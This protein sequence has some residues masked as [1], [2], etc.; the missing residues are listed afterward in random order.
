MRILLFIMSIV[1]TQTI[2][3]QELYLLVGTYTSGNSEGIYVCRFNTSTGEIKLV[4]TAKSSNPSYLAIAGKSIYAVNENGGKNGGEV[5]A[6]HFDRKSG[7]LDFLNKQ[8]TGGDHPCY[9]AVDRSK[10]TLLAGNYS[11]GNFSVFPINTDGSLEAYSRLVQNEGNGPDHSRQEK[12]HVHATVFGP[13]QESVW[14]TD[15]GTDEI[16]IYEYDRET[17][18][19]KNEIGSIAITPGGGPRHIAFSSNKKFVF[20]LEELSGMVS[21]YDTKSLGLV[22]RLDSHP[23]GYKGERGSADIHVSPDGKFLY[24]SNR[25]DAN[26]LVIYSIDKK[27]GRL[28]TKGFQPVQGSKPRNFIISP[29]GKFLLVANQQTNNIVIFKRDKDTGLLT[30]L[31]KQFEVPNPVCLK[32]ASID[33]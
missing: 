28:E 14:V 2:S 23:E 9:V 1:A 18:V 11:G 20:V 33:E 25:G 13:D 27:T 15:L 32:L 30:P 8:F 29:D 7:K 10:K 4:S 31:P 21:V 17:A 6:F 19:V 3:S 24:A 5:S 12:A 16:S 26:N 22:Q